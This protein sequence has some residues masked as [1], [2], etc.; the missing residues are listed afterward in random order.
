MNV[1][2]EPSGVARGKCKAISH[3]FILEVVSSHA[4]SLSVSK[5][6]Q[7]L[8][9]AKQSLRE[10][11][12]I[13]NI[14]WSYEGKGEFIAEYWNLEWCCSRRGEGGEV[15]PPKK[16]S[17]LLSTRVRYRK[18]HF[19]PQV[20]VYYTFDLV[21]YIYIFLVFFTSDIFVILIATHLNLWMKLV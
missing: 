19:S 1:L 16:L 21:S 15:M 7:F 4:L 6:N 11:T 13:E 5:N 9:R 20:S 18:L 14:C 3:S 2:R 10:E 17:V 12:W 8:R